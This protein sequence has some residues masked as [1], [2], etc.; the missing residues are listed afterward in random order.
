MQGLSSRTPGC[1]SR[2]ASSSTS[3]LSRSTER[4][5]NGMRPSHRC[6]LENP[7]P[8]PIAIVPPF[9]ACLTCQVSAGIRTVSRRRRRRMVFV[10]LSSGVWACYIG[11]Q[12]DQPHETRSRGRLRPDTRGLH[13]LCRGTARRQPPG[14][15]P[16][17][18]PGSA[19][20]RPSSS[21]STPIASWPREKLGSGAV[22]R[23]RPR[24]RRE[25]DRTRPPPRSPRVSSCREARYRSM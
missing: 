6:Q 13:G 9:R 24:T 16:R 8:L 14:G 2:T 21:S 25:A 1:P 17:G 22:I 4:L 23:R 7:R 19:C 11:E 10:S 20:R 15:C 12:K 18:S 3:W 5:A